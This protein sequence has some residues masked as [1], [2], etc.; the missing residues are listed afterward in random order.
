MALQPFLSPLIADTGISFGDEGKGRLISEVVREL[1]DSTGR[2]DPV[3]IV[4]KVNGGANSGHTAGGLKLN[5]LPGG[6]IEESVPILGLGS[7]VV[8]DPRKLWWETKAT[9]SRGFEVL[10]RLRID[11]RT[12]VSDLGHRLLDLAWESYRENQLKLPARGSTGRGITPSY[13]DEVGQ[14]QIYYADFLGCPDRF[15][16]RFDSRLDRAL[17][18][19]KEVCQVTEDEWFN[20]FETLSN[21]ESRANEPAVADGAFPPEE[22]DFRRFRGER[23]FE[24]DRDALF[25][26]YWETGNLF[27]EAIAD[28][29]ELVLTTIE[30]GQSVI[31]E[32]GQAYW[33]DKRHGFAP[34]VTASHSY[35]PEFFQS[36]GIPVQPL[37]TFGVCKAYDTK[38]GTHDFLTEMPLEDSLAIKLRKLEFGT[39][40]GRQRMVGWFD[41]VEKGTALRYGGFD[42]LVINKLDALT[43]GDSWEGKLRICTGYQAPDGTVYNRVPRN[44]VVRRECKAIYEDFDG[45][46]EDICEARSFDALPAEA[47]RYVAA[48]TY[49]TLASAYGTE[50]WPEKL[51]NL[52]YI[53]VGPDPDEIIKDIPETAAIIE[54]FKS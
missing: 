8:A 47:Q 19:I 36:A 25:E 54:L 5:L 1:Q 46:D 33:L 13:L 11:E 43:R 49:Y 31:G 29:R 20:F 30:N 40:T 14:W 18:T 37:H 15:R 10:S 3:R 42:D 2:P 34:N 21:A 6:V 7:G 22:F 39:S 45:W 28:I 48:M 38:V 23:P 52:R 51:P 50:Q 41:A 53:G 35:T 4:L 12:M 16:K 27:A 24:L 44:E 9:E 32:F 17:L 26:T